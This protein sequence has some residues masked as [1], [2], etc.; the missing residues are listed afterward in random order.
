MSAAISRVA[1]CHG[2]TRCPKASP[3]TR[4]YA[5]GRAA[6]RARPGRRRPRPAA[7]GP[8]A[9]PELPPVEVDQAAVELE[10]PVG[11]CPAG[12]PPRSSGT[13]KPPPPRCSASIGAAGGRTVS[14]TAPIHCTYANSRCFGSVR[15][16]YECRAELRISVRPPARLGS[17]SH[18]GAVVR[19]LHVARGRRQRAQ[20]GPDQPDRGQHRPG[21]RPARLRQGRAGAAQVPAEPEAGHRQQRRQRQHDPAARHR[22][23]E[24]EPGAQRGGDRAQG[25]EAGQPADHLAGPAQVAELQLDHQRGDRGEQE[26][27]QEDAIAASSSTA[28][29]APPRS[30]SPPQRTSGSVTAVPI[31]AR[32]SAGASSAR[33]SNRSASR[34]PSHVP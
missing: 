5:A 30:T 21:T 8:V 24:D 23:D 6:R 14:A 18:P 20:P 4:S 29:A 13:V 10:R 15:S 3:T 27:G 16:T 11:R 1:R 22:G 26:R 34:P 19:R 31:A 7:P 33:G 32:I 28:G 25:A 12:W 17:S 2:T 9:Q